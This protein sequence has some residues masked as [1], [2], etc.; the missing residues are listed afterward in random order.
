MVIDDDGMEYDR[1][2][3]LCHPGFSL[4]GDITELTGLQREDLASQGDAST[5]LNAFL[6]WLPDHTT[7]VAHNASFDATLLQYEA[8]LAGIRCNH[9][10]IVD[11]VPWARAMALGS[12]K[13]Q[14]LVKD[15]N[16][17]YGDAHRAMPDALATVDLWRLAKDR[18]GTEAMRAL[19]LLSHC[20]DVGGVQVLY[21]LR[22]CTL[23]DSFRKVAP[24]ALAIAMRV[25]KAVNVLFDLGVMR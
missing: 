22:S 7:L 9:L 18:L 6:T 14:Q 12:L 13:L 17:Q 8:E 16:W 25:V 24:C 20:P 19:T 11:T 4:P 10:R 23:T 1:F 3:M 21:R 15:F 2:E 5:V